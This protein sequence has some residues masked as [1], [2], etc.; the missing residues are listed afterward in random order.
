MKRMTVALLLALFLVSGCQSYKAELAENNRNLLKLEIGMNK[1]QVLEIM[2][3]PNMNEA[4][5]SLKGIPTTIWFY[6]TER[7]WADGSYTKDEMTPLVFHE[8]KLSGWG[9]EFYENKVI[10][11]IRRR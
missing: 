7:K 8:G 10:Y 6:Y 5:Q 4:Y 9:D 1:E 11:E 2:G 3:E